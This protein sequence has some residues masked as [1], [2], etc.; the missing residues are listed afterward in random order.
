MKKSGTILINSPDQ[1]D[2]TKNKEIEKLDVLVEESNKILYEVSSVFPFQLFP[3]KIIVDSNKVTIIHK[4]L[5]SKYTFPILIEDLQTVKLSRGLIFAS[6]S[7]EIRRFEENPGPVSHLW[8]E[9]AA[10]AE[11]IIL[12]LLSAKRG[13]LNVTKIP[14]KEFKKK[15]EKIGTS[16]ESEKPQ[17]LF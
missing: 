5:F 11:K 13:G 8:P 3:D 14:S 9:K 17:N 10:K 12:G 4:W 6:L 1:K 7:F 15:I 2:T 16:S